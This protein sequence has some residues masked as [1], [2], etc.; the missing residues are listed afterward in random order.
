MYKR[1]INKVLKALSDD[2]RQSKYR[3]NNDL[4][5]YCYVTS[6]ALYHMLGGKRAGWKP[7]FV[8]HEGKPHWFLL[9]ENGCILDITA[10]QFNTPVPVYSAK[11]KG[12]LTKLPSKRAQIL[13]ERV[14]GAHHD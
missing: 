8:R 13:I 2:L 1:L 6:E 3:G 14:T 4:S 11:G 12:F 9:H 7:M 10:E 5:G